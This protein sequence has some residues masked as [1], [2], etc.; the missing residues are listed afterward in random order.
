MT[1]GTG[2]GRGLPWWR[3]W[4]GKMRVWRHECGAPPMVGLAR[5][6]RVVHTIRAEKRV[7]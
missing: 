4:R 1:D 5:P 7:S 2:P 6:G 3:W